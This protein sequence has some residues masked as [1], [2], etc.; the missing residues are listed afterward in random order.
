MILFG[1][2]SAS[3]FGKWDY[4]A[5][6]RSV[7]PSGRRGSNPRPSAWEADA[8]PCL[9]TVKQDKTRIRTAIVLAPAIVAALLIANPTNRIVREMFGRRG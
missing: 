6:N 4:E 8:T 5:T 7:K 9:L 3:P 1:N 2:C